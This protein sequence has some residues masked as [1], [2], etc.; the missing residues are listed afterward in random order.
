MSTEVREACARASSARTV[1]AYRGRT[2]EADAALLAALGKPGKA[3][4]L[5][6]TWR[7]RYAPPLA[8]DP[9]LGNLAPARGMP[10]GA[11][12]LRCAEEVF[13]SRID[14][15]IRNVWRS[16]TMQKARRG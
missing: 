2:E 11:P 1:L 14:L 15:R 13:R 8:V 7:D 6:P 16:L 9:C 3:R 12:Q 4:R 5:T 10:V